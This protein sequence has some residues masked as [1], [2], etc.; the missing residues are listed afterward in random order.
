MLKHWGQQQT[1]IT[2]K[3]YQNYHH[4]LLFCGTTVAKTA[5][6]NILGFLESLSFSIVYKDVQPFFTRT[7]E[8]VFK[9]SS[10]HH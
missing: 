7:I 5:V 2:H 9:N 1:I 4:V 6:Y 3:T 8:E 10:E